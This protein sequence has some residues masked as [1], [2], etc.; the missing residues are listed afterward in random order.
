MVEIPTTAQV[1]HGY[2]IVDGGLNVTWLREDAEKRFD[3]WF[4]EVKAE[5]RQ[6]ERQSVI[7]RLVAQD[8]DRTILAAIVD[9]I[10]GEE[11]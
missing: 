8:L 10:E 9:L 3:R 7:K 6:A 11:K 5:E 4:S 2:S 1:R